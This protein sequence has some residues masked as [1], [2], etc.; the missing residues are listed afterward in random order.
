MGP[1]VV[2][3]MRSVSTSDLLGWRNRSAKLD[4]IFG[5]ARNAL[6]TG[7]NMFLHAFTWSGRFLHVLNFFLF[8]PWRDLR[9][10]YVSWVTPGWKPGG[11][12]SY[13]VDRCRFAQPHDV[14]ACPLFL[15]GCLS[16][17]QIKSTSPLY[18]CTLQIAC[19]YGICSRW[20]PNSS[21]LAV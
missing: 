6:R 4:I 5:C 21:K 16:G 3:K 12:R 14:G 11:C 9:L 10:C 13:F 15:R 8:R 19:S 1:R 17:N 2:Q 18:S 20:P 7:F